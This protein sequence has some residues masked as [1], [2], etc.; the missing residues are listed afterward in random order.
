MLN[1]ALYYLHYMDYYNTH[2]NFTY[3][4]RV[5][6]FPFPV[7]LALHYLT[8]PISGRLKDL[9]QRHYFTSVDLLIV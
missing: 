5:S 1:C 9:A 7:Q 3:W 2:V 6:F 4:M 8:Q